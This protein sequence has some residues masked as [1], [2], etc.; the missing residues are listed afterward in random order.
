MSEAPR[1]AAGLFFWA[2]SCTTDHRDR[3]KS[4]AV[5]ISSRVDWQQCGYVTLTPRLAQLH[6]FHR[7]LFIAV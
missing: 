4:C 3:S 6:E 2:A 1:T 7:T 5:A